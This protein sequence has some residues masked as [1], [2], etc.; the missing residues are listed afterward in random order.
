MELP[1]SIQEY[2]Q[3]LVPSWHHQVVVNSTSGMTAAMVADDV[4][5]MIL[6]Q[7]EEMQWSVILNTVS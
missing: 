5:L 1:G 2:P 7:S 6:S 4:L 3:E